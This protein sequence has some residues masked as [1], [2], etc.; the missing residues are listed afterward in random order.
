MARQKREGR[1][2]GRPCGVEPDLSAAR[3]VEWLAQVGN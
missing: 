3:G 1:M 2:R